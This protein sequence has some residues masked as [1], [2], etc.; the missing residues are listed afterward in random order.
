MRTARPAASEARAPEARADDPLVDPLH[1]D[2]ALADPLVRPGPARSTAAPPPSRPVVQAMFMGA[3][4]MIEVL[5]DLAR[6]ADNADLADEIE[7][8]ESLQDVTRSQV[9]ALYMAAQSDQGI[10]GKLRAVL[11]SGA[12]EVARVMLELLEELP[13]QEE[14]IEEDV[15][16]E[17]DFESIIRKAVEVHAPIVGGLIEEARSRATKSGKKLLVIVGEQHDDP[18]GRVMLTILVGAIQRLAVGKLYVESTPEKVKEHVEPYRK[19]EPKSDAKDEFGHKQHF[20]RA[21]YGQGAEIQGVDIFKEIADEKAQ[22]QLG[23]EPEVGKDEWKAKMMERKIAIRNVGMAKA[24]TEAPESGVL[25][26]GLTHLPGLASDEAIRDSYEI[27]SVAAALP[28]MAAGRDFMAYG[29]VL[30]HTEAL[31]QMKDLYVGA[32]E[33]SGT[34]SVA[35]LDPVAT[36]ALAKQMTVEVD[37]L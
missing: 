5:L 10:V 30:G 16:E 19:Q 35:D 6:E 18:Y 29:R 3:A 28:K 32:D 27:V 14:V 11:D 26:V 2:G 31:G 23:P 9:Q 17:P 4:S 33:D 24:L 12:A 25:L 13:T 7:A 21:L 22:D 37:E 20:F 8:I 15:V 34:H 1:D 36:Y